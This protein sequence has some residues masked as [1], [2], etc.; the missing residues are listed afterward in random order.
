MLACDVSLRA[1]EAP[2]GLV[3]LSGAPISVPEWQN[4]APKRAGLRV[5][6]SHGQ[7][8]PILPF[9]GGV[10]LRD[11]L[12]QAGLKVEF[13]EWNGGHGIPDGVVE[14]LGPF[15]TECTREPA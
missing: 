4:L 11:L 7:S 8:D 12:M 6:M 10:Y 15:V 2:A 1:D 13:M 9:A 3:L 14:R 5:L